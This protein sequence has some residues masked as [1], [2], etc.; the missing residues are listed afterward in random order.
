MLSVI[1]PSAA[2]C[3]TSEASTAL[4]SFAPLTVGRVVLTPAP[5]NPTPAKEAFV[6]IYTPCDGSITMGA[7]IDAPV[8]DQQQIAA[9]VTCPPHAEL[10]LL[11]NSSWATFP[12]TESTISSRPTTGFS[13]QLAVREYS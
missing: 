12:V 4:P 8:S 10:P 6:K 1:R 9:R 3:C 13:H 2:S 11:L 7:A 5:E